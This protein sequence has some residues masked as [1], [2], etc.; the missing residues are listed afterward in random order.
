LAPSQPQPQEKSPSSATEPL[1]AT[2]ADS[3]GAR[4][5]IKTE[6]PAAGLDREGYYDLP[7]YTDSDGTSFVRQ[8]PGSCLRLVVNSVARLAE[9]EPG[10]PA[11]VTIDPPRWSTAVLEAVDNLGKTVVRLGGAENRIAE[12]TFDESIIGGRKQNGIV[13]ARRFI[14]WM[15]AVNPAL[16]YKNNSSK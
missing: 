2:R 1:P 6:L 15:R 9:T 4:A 12:L 10:E 7:A 5:D 14:R 11:K 3:V 13:Q 8:R 16:Q